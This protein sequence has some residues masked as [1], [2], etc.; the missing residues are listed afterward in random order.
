MT[1]VNDNRH[2][3]FLL[4]LVVI[5]WGLNVV[6]IKYLTSFFPPLALA[7][8]RLCLASALL[9]PL[10]L[11][12]HGYKK[13]SRKE[14]LP[15]IG[16]ATFCIFLHQIALN[17]GLTA[18]SGMHA[19][20]ILG[21]NPLFTTTSAGYLLKEE[22]TW[23]KGIAILLGFGGLLLVVSG[24]SQGGATLFGDGI[25]LIAT[26]TFVI[27]SLFVKKATVSVSPLVVTAY[28]HTLASIGLL[29]LGLSVNPEWSYPGSFGFWP[30]IV[31]LSS[32]FLSTALGA[33]WWNTAIQKVGAS[34]ASL[35]QNASPI[36]GVL[37]SAFFLGEQLNWYHFVALFLVL[38]GVSLGTG[39]I[40]IP[41]RLVILKNRLQQ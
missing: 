13:L 31:L 26:I 32:S 30:I 34:T 20:L 8:I 22:F 6:A 24:K 5:L 41:A 38:L 17:I 4:I 35:F 2:V 39:V 28:S 3:F 33:L 36:V 16:V 10:V 29:I 1:K 9:L 18:T 25:V 19:V 12:K 21:L 40:N 37:A 7:P 23:A 27:G 14:W 11:K 15:I